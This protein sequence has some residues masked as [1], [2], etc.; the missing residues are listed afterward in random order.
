MAVMLP[1][2]LGAVVGVVMVGL[3]YAGPTSAATVRTIYFEATNLAIISGDPFGA[4]G[5]GIAPPATVTGSFSFDTTSY[6]SFQQP[7]G[8]IDAFYNYTSFS[9]QIGTETIFGSTSSGGSDPDRIRVRDGATNQTDQIE[10][11]SDTNNT[12]TLASGAILNFMQI[13]LQSPG[14]TYQG[15]DFP[16][17][18]TLNSMNSFTQLYIGLNGNGVTH[19]GWLGNVQYL[20]LT[21]TETVIPL[22]AALPLFATALA[23]MGLLGWRRKR[24]A[25]A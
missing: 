7:N 18:D 2:L 16:S 12:T 9:A 10:I 1:R 22:P 13:F 15:T 8:S 3:T 4:E 5:F 24:K 17:V 6:G 14:D 25:A 23:G 21:F 11:V 20:D 19:G